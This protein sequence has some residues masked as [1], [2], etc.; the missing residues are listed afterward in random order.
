MKNKFNL[1]FGIFLLLNVG[2]I[3]AHGEDTF[4]EAELIIQQKISCDD[5]TESQLEIL[6]DYYMEQMHPGELHE[7]MDERMGGEGSESL[8]QIHIN[9][10]LAFYC[11]EQDSFSGNMMNMMM[12][13]TYGM[14]GGMMGSYYYKTNYFAWTFNILLIVGLVLLIVWL[15]KELKNKKHNRRR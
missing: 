10:G 15:I 1:I 7:L 14:Y 11:E 3:S 12:G 2:F 8:K 5:L 9:M 13:G 6:G 4:A